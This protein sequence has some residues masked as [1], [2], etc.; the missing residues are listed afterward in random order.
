MLGDRDLAEVLMDVHP[1]E[2]HL[3]LPS[4]DNGGRADGRNDNGGYVLTAHPGQVA[5][6]ATRNNGPAA[7]RT[8]TAYPPRSRPRRAP[9][10]EADDATHAASPASKAHADHRSF[11]PGD[12]YLERP[13][14]A[15]GSSLHA[16][17][18]AR[19]SV[20]CLGDDRSTRVGERRRLGSA[21][22]P[23]RPLPRSSAWT[24][25]SQKTTAVTR[26]ASATPSASDGPDS[27][28]PRSP[29]PRGRGSRR[30][31]RFRSCGRRAGT[32]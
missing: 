23:A 24:W 18:G 12:W 14:V 28:R 15:V 6:A 26:T 25:A 21:S 1:D 19:A 5:G 29:P 11:M 17:F 3:R 13:P 8:A 10:P 9:V 7:H 4:L 16:G 31:S 27:A 32:R 20:L 30:R 22:V 2:P